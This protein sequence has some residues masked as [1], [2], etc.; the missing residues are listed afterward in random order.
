MK[1]G[2]KKYFFAL[3]F[4]VILG[5]FFRTYNFERGF[6]FAQDQDLYSLIA[7]DIVVDR[8]MRLVGQ[9]TSVDGVF[10]GSMYYY[11]MAITYSFFNMNPM[12][13]ILPLTLIGIFNILS[14]FWISKRFYGKKVALIAATISSISFG[15]AYYERWS[16]PTQPTISWCLWFMFV[17][18]EFCR[19]R[20][21][22]LWLY[23]VLVALT[24]QVHIALLPILPIPIVSYFL[25]KGRLREKIKKVSPKNIFLAL[26]I[27]FLVSS[28]FWIFEIKHNFSQIRS[29]VAATTRGGYEGPVGMQKFY[30]VLDAS[31]R[32]IQ[33]RLLFGWKVVLVN[34]VWLLI[35]MMIVF[36]GVKKKLLLAEIISFCLWFF[37]IMLAQ[38]SSKNVVSEYYFTN[39]LPILIVLFSL[40]L[41][42]LRKE[43]LYI[44]GLGYFLINLGWLLT[45]SDIY[46]SYFYRMRIVEDIKADI[47]ENSYPCIAINYIADPGFGVGFRYL[48]WYSGIRVIKASDKV[49]V[50]DIVIP[51]QVS[52]DEIDLREGC[53]GLIKPKNKILVDPA[54]CQDIRYKLDPLL[55]YTE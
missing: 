13:A 17:V 30:K 9:M 50:Y 21:K 6:S 15:M 52:G 33:Q 45:R 55:G 35:P 54:V 16:V 23:A 38:F 27:F 48:M 51:W 25:S 2:F 29:V 36:L 42:F 40:S 8:H 34:W 4:V 3:L 39:M 47:L 49:P 53:F 24:W 41:W 22:H 26:G 18:L 32:E 31:G 14:I 20:L 11:L 1:E 12:S 37:L 46:D 28:P 5:I 10:I 43:L 19:G 7:K 44:L